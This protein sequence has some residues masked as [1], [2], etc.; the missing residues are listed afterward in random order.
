LAFGPHNLE[1]FSTV[2]KSCAIT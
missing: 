2:W 1:L